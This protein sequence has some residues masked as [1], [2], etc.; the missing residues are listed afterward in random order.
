MG[1]FSLAGKV[2]IVTGGA[3]GLGY[4]FVIQLLENGVKGVTLVDISTKNGNIAFQ[5]FQAKYGKDRVL[6]VHA[7]ITKFE[8]FEYVFKQTLS[9]F[10]NID[11]LIN[12]AGVLCDGQWNREIDVNVKGPIN[13]M[14][15]GLENYLPKYKSG[16]EGVIVNISSIAGV[17]PFGGIPVYTATKFFVHGVT[18]A[19]GTPA[20]YNRSK[21]RVVGI[22]PGVTK[23]PMIEIASDGILSPVYKELLDLEVAQCPIQN[24]DVVA[25]SLVNVIQRGPSGT[26]WVVEGGEPPYKFELPDRNKLPK[27]LLP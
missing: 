18:A 21:I 9:T 20:N 19:W 15:L 27:V 6:F 24:P 5:E 7:D 4:Q 22:C 2:A 16:D 10:H 26:M 3:S 14:I 8:D 25:L 12:N 11:I 13:G 1:S 17:Q 23:T